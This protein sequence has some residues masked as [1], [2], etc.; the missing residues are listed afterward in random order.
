MPRPLRRLQAR[1]RGQGA[2]AAR[3]SRWQ[4]GSASARPSTGA[5]GPTWLWSRAAFPTARVEAE[6]PDAAK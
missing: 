3:F 1:R 6:Q 2:A 5:V 4:P